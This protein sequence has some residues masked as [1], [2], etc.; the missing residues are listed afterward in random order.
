MLISE[1]GSIKWHT[2]R[3]Y[4]VT[5][6]RL[7]SIIIYSKNRWHDLAMNYSGIKT[8]NPSMMAQFRMDTGTQMEDL[9]RQEFIGETGLSVEVPS[10]CV[11]LDDPW[12]AGSPDGFTSDGGCLE[13]KVSFDPLPPL[14]PNGDQVPDSHYLQ[15]MANCHISGRPFCWYVV[16][17]IPDKKMYY[18]KIYYE[19]QC[20]TQV[21][22]PIGRQFIET[23][24]K[25][26]SLID[27][28]DPKIRAHI[29]AECPQ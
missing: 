27:Y 10:L 11:Y 25:P 17:S 13:I 20:W 5:S 3:K 28:D 7:G 18:Q 4:R 6:S 12:F 22:Y 15:M 19:P 24:L 1:Q 21:I 16:Y 8:E 26:I 2:A 29:R 23:Q 9:I 14:R